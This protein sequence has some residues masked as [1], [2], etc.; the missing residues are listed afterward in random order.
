MDFPIL[1]MVIFHSYVEVPEGINSLQ[2]LM[3]F[4]FQGSLI[5]GQGNP[6]MAG[7]YCEVLFLRVDFILF[8]NIADKLHT[9]EECLEILMRS[10][11]PGRGLKK[12]KSRLGAGI[13][14]MCFPVITYSRY[15]IHNFN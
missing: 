11:P 10:P 4:F 9:S 6:A 2:S 1:N 5:P 12:K 7:H 3:A 13:I 8:V 15:S 14:Y